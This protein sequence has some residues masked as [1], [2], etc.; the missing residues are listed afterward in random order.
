MLAYELHVSI[1]LLVGLLI[2]AVVFYQS[3]PKR[4]ELEISGNYE[5]LEGDE[6]SLDGDPRDRDVFDI[7][8]AEDMID[9]YP[10]NEAEFWAKVCL[11]FRTITVWCSFDPRH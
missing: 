4:I 7:V 11:P 9:G 6:P 8:K 3:R 2:S 10:I 1:T 5:P